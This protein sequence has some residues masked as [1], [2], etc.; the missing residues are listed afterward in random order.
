MC[1]SHKFEKYAMCVINIS[2]LG[3]F[4]ILDILI[5]RK[6]SI[7]FNIV[8][9]TSTLEFRIWLFL[10]SYCLLLLQFIF[11]KDCIRCPTFS[12]LKALLLNEWCVVADIGALVC[13]LRHTPVLEKLTIQLPRYKVYDFVSMVALSC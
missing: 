13:F 3:S 8:R 10:V 12:M 6:A 4:R 5:L 11:R 1:A 2:L 9:L 7:Q